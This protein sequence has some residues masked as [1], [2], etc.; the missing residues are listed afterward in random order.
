MSRVLRTVAIAVLSLVVLAGTEGRPRSRA[1]DSLIPR[2]I[3]AYG[4]PSS[5]APLAS[6]LS[7]DGRRVAVLAILPPASLGAG[8]YPLT[9]QIW[10]AS[11]LKLLVSREIAVPR[12]APG[13][14]TTSDRTIEPLG[15]LVR[16][17][18]DGA[19]L[20]VSEGSALERSDAATPFLSASAAHLHIL[21]ADDLREIRSIDLSLS[22]DPAVY[23]TTDVRVSPAGDRIAV[24]LSP[25]DLLMSLGAG[26]TCKAFL[27]SEV[28]VYDSRSGECLWKVS[29][30]LARIGS[31]AWAPDGSQLALTLQSAN[32]SD[33]SSRGAFCPEPRVGNNLLI[34]DA[35]SGRALR[36]I[37]TGDL[38]GPICF[39]TNNLVFT[40]PFHFFYVNSSGETVKVWNVQTGA[41]ERTIGYPGRDVHDLLALSRDGSI[42]AA[43]VG[44]E[45][46]GFSSRAQEEVAQ[47]VDEK[48]ALWDARTG[49]LFRTSPVLSP[50]TRPEMRASIKDPNSWLPMP[51]R[52]LGSLILQS[53][54]N[55]DKPQLQLA[56]DGSRVLVSWK[57][58]GEPLILDVAAAGKPH[59]K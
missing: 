51:L 58:R 49:T 45:K 47:N 32:E 16:Y 54:G 5:G 30:D 41:L 38:A 27:A 21:A 43:Y 31:V 14:S 8:P 11:D 33:T 3:P 39:G 52:Q 53:P 59:A 55:P 19:S 9:L 13:A 20:V 44:K 23:E 56:A 50:L 10:D 6:A 1:K 57:W 40:A 25:I 2:A 26:A 48:F 36:G 37:S 18:A 15:C 42:L 7:A 28:R 46:F 34:L 24:A 17:A 35:A 12:H 4:S 29:Y 22:P